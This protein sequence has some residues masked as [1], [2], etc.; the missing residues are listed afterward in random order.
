MVHNPAAVLCTKDNQ[1]EHREAKDLTFVSQA[2]CGH[3]AVQETVYR[4]R[5]ID[6]SEQIQTREFS[7]ISITNTRN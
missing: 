7:T 3:T 5:W 4:D 2:L 6:T 1:E